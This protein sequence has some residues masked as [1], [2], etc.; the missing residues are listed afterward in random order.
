MDPTKNVNRHVEGERNSRAQGLFAGRGT[1]R[2][3]QTMG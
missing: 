2:Q 3:I 1:N